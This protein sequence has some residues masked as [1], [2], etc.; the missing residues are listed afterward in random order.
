MRERL[1]QSMKEAMKSG[2]KKRLSTL[3]LV[4][5]A[6]KDRDIAARADEK[7]QATGSDKIGEPE[8]LALLQKM[9]KQRRDSADT[10]R[11]GGREELAEGEE[12]EIAI[13]EEYL[14]QQMGDEEVREA[15]KSAIEETGCCGLKDMGKIMGVLKK[16]YTGRMDFGKAS[17]IVKSAL[18]ES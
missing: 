16:R 6:I 13:I 12:A 2:D 8:I 7:G 10:Y 17:A 18:K 5:A 9:I 11:K 4:N 3:R 15:V 14:P 1:N